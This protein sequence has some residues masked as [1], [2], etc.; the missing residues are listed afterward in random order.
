MFGADGRAMSPWLSSAYKGRKYAYYIPQK[1]IAEGAGASGLPRLQA[2]NLNDQV[3]LS[4]RQLLSSPEQ[5]L[6]YLP[7][8]LTESP[9]FDL[10]LVVKR[11]MHFEGLSDELFPIHQKN[12]VAQLIERVTVHADRLD[13]D[14]RLGGLMD[15][16]LEL[17]A[18]RPDL[19]RAYRQL[20]SSSRSHGL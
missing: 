2:A 3:W 16:I 5:L 17:L 12:L 11:L 1:E 4:L 7:K 8:P 20:Y 9:E 18:D 6:A 14:F 13:I 19:V 15:L 10:S